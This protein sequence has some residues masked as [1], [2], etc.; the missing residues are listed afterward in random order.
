MK[1]VQTNTMKLVE[2][3]KKKL[4]EVQKILPDG[5]KV[6]VLYDQSYLTQKA[7]STVERALIEGIVLVSLAI[8]LN[9]WNIR[10]A[11]LQA[12]SVKVS[13]LITFKFLMIE[14]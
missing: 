1:R 10:V 14:G 4:E 5:L 11:L 13:L 3:L 12:L 6:E 2:E 9:M 7:L 8:A